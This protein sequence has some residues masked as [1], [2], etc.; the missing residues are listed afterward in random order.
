MEILLERNRRVNLILSPQQLRAD[1]GDHSLRLLHY[2]QCVETEE[3]ILLYNLLTGELVKVKGIEEEKEELYRKYFLVPGEHDDFLLF[4]QFTELIS[5]LEIRGMKYINSYT[6][7]PTTDCNARCFYCYEKGTERLNM[8]SET[9]ERVTEYIL[10]NANHS[11]PVKLSWFG[12]EPLCNCSAIDQICSS[13]KNGMIDFSSSMTSNGYLFDDELIIKARELWRLEKVQ[14]TLD[15]TEEVYN[16]RKAY[17]Y[18][19]DESPFRRV[20]RNIAALS[21]AGITVDIRLNLDHS[22][23]ED[24]LRLI[25]CVGE[26]LSGRDNVFIY[27]H[28]LFQCSE[29]ENIPELKHAVEEKIEKNG[30]YKKR[31]FRL[32][33]RTN[34]CM[35][36]SVNSIIIM[37]DGTLHA[38]EHFNVQQA[39]GTIEEN[40]N[41]KKAVSYYRE[42]I[43]E[44]QCR[45]CPVLPVCFRL[46]H[47]PNTKSGC[48]GEKA[49]KIAGLIRESVAHYVNE[50]ES[51]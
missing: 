16:R 4:K 42:R 40:G 47:C 32:G 23:Q 51:V 25:D 1:G 46:K 33:L 2:V 41:K 12:G 36:D 35:A 9:A 49:E 17:I 20:I 5:T 22:N 11:A 21:D 15:G 29:E 30:F 50:N 6:I 27:C 26:S 8:S 38:C 24:L 39:I 34:G 37:P 44:E 45:T 3:E 31:D 48:S 19:A 18:I 43:I 13:L 10:G 28:E 7:L 14:I